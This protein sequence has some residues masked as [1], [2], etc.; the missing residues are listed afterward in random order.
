MTTSQQRVCHVTF[1]ICET[2][3]ADALQKCEQPFP[4]GKH[5]HKGVI[6]QPPNHL[7]RYSS[8]FLLV[9]TAEN[10]ANE[11]LWPYKENETETPW[12][13]VEYCNVHCR[14]TQ[15][16]YSGIINTATHEDEDLLFSGHLC[17]SVCMLFSCFSFLCSKLPVCLAPSLFFCD[18]NPQKLLKLPFNRFNQALCL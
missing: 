6:F 1:L 11:D 7:L 4:A 15:H 18:T 13:F 8:F 9:T 16:F 12:E 2:Q 3:H 17:P 14:C 5:P 10:A